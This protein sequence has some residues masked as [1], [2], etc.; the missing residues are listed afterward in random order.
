VSLPQ[1]KE[2]ER[3]EN[4]REEEEVGV[5]RLEGVPEVFLGSGICFWLP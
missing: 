4:R 5:R 2:P 3:L 1:P